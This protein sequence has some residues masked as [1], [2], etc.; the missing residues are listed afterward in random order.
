MGGE[1]EVLTV[2]YSFTQQQYVGFSMELLKSNPPKA[3]QLL[4][5]TSLLGVVLLNPF[6]Q[7]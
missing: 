7:T 4:S 6:L 3:E 5:E 1:G 2:A